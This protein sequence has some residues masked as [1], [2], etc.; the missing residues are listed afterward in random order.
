MADPTDDDHKLRDGR[1]RFSRTLQGAQRDAYAAQLRAQRWTYQQ[2]A[3]ELG[4]DKSNA[5]MAV[6]RAIRDAC[7]GPGKE[8][9]DL[10][11]TRLE[12]M[13]DEVLDILNADHVLV[14]H[15]KVIYDQAGNPLP[16]YDIK[17]RAIDRALRAR[18]SFRKLLGLDA[19]VKVDATVHEVTQQ[20]L[21]LQEMLREA[22][23]R[24]D[25]EERQILDG[26]T[27]G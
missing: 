6:R 20:D 16:D 1:G 7:A 3:D 11:V 8:L 13:Y 25:L 2:I 4:I 26:G 24:T 5:I 9:V 17:L 18:E 21:E 22:K 23:A 19:A 10:E 27:D 14:S 12:A 15:G